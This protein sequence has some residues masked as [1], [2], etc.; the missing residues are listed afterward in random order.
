MHNMFY[1]Y[2]TF[3]VKEEGLVKL[4]GGASAAVL[5]HSGLS[6]HLFVKPSLSTKQYYTVYSSRMPFYEFLRERVFLR[7]ENGIYP[8]WYVFL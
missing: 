2:S 6:S 4:W 7:D 3:T 5:R 1:S 8:L